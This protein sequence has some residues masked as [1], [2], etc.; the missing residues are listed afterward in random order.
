MHINAKYCIT[1]CNSYSIFLLESKVRNN[2][3]NFCNSSACLCNNNAIFLS[4]FTP[5]IHCGQS[6]LLCHSNGV[7]SV[8]TSFLMIPRQALSKV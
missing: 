1:S 6:S 5:Y 8:Q 3:I 7:T 4:E 2:F